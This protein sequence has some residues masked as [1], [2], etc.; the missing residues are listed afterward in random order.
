M[1]PHPPRS[2]T[3]QPNRAK[4]AKRAKT[5]ARLLDAALE[6]TRRQGFDRTTLQDIAAHAG[7]TTGSIYGNFK[8]RDDLFMALA[9]RQWGPPRPRYTSGDSFAELM[10]AM[11]QATIDTIAEREPAAVGALTY[12]AYVLRDDAL[13]A[14]FCATMAQGLDAG[15]KWLDDN[16][17]A[18]ALPMPSHL[19]VRVI[20]ALIEGLT[21]Q[22]VFAKAETSDE[23]IYA[24]FRALAQR[25]RP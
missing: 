24:A 15:A 5:R 22:R 17:A 18:E 16:F 9:Q 7:V 20:D 8:N 14:Q 1:L 2:A 21:F 25:A 23:V 19:L 11:A 6:L 12:R 4:G 10:E 13:R 3:P